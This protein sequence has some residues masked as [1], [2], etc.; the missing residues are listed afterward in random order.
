LLMRGLAK[1]PLRID[2]V[3]GGKNVH[4]LLNAQLAGLATQSKKNIFPLNGLTSTPQKT[5]GSL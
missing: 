1:K 2:P 4:V 3:Y 5:T